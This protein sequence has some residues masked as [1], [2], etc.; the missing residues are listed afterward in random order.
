MGGG[1]WARSMGR[2]G[3]FSRAGGPPR[4]RKGARGRPVAAPPDP[5]LGGG[6]N[7]RARA[8]PGEATFVWAA[9]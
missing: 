8:R 7:P 2:G 1:A 9:A 5:A 4:P 6:C 3:R